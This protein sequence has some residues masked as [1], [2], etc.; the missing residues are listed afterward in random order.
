MI[1]F[2]YQNDKILFRYYP[3]F[4]NQENWVDRVIEDNGWVRFKNTFYFEREDLIETTNNDERDGFE[5]QED[6]E[7]PTPSTFIF[8]T[9][10][11]QYFKIKRGILVE[12]FDIYIHQ[13]IYP[14]TIYFVAN[15]NISVFNI[16]K[17]I[18]QQ[19][20]YLGGNNP[21][22]IPVEDFEL[23]I[24]NF[25]T[26]Y[27]KRKYTEARIASVLRNHL[28]N[29][30]DAEKIFRDYLNRKQS[31]EGNNLTKTF[32]DS[33]LFKF[34]T[35]FEKLKKMLDSEIEYNERQWQEEILQI[36]LLLYPKYLFAF[37][38][39]PVIAKV[40]ENLSQKFLDFLLVDNNGNVDIVE[41]KK[42]FENAIMTK[43]YYRDNYIPLRELSGTV[44]QVEKY[45]Y[46]LNRWSYEGE[47]YLT[48]KYKDELPD[49]FDI[50]ITNPGAIIIMGR[51]N[52]LISQQ[53]RDFEVV[54][55]KYKNIIDILTYDNL[56]KRLSV[57][58]EQIKRQ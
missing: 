39:V 24:K 41:I 32:R 22:S 37:R 46:Y 53:K 54:K 23:L 3:E 28:E 17:N 58:I 49:G 15:S 21:N 4:P 50:K 10:H 44:M 30:K 25:P 48:N 43:S 13:D 35:I 6:A 14:K 31:K 40:A 52:N 42:P 38:E 51:E 55:R 57:T 12:E 16:I 19:Q 29:V 2:L 20:F 5:D 47:K 1:S 27:E 33:E 36:V 26:P 8:A 56:L 45:V 9:L 18:T 34:Q 11:D 7:G